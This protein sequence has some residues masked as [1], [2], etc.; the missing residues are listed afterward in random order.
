MGNKSLE[1]LIHTIGMYCAYIKTEEVAPHSFL[2]CKF[3]SGIN[4]GLNMNAH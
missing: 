3:I 1:Y 4:E 2:N